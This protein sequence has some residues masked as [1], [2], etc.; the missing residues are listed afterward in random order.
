MWKVFH[1]S[2]TTNALSFDEV[3]SL[4]LLFLLTGALVNRPDEYKWP[5]IPYVAHYVEHIIRYMYALRSALK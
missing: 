4:Q 5:Y 2:K 1:I 3:D